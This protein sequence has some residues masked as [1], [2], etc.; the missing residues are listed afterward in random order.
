VGDRPQLRVTVYA[1]NFGPYGFVFKFA[2]ALMALL[3]RRAGVLSD[4]RLRL[5]PP[6]AISL[7]LG[8]VGGT[9]VL[10]PVLLL[11]T[12]NENDG[13]R[14]FL[15]RSQDELVTQGRMEY[16][17]E[18][19]RRYQQC[20]R[21]AARLTT[22]RYGPTFTFL[23]GVANE[24]IEA[25]GQASVGLNPLRRENID[26]TLEDLGANWRGVKDAIAASVGTL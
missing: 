16:P 23:G 21:L 13:F 24:A 11:G 6:P 22:E 17:T 10:S 9:L 18:N 2:A 12:S 15:G 26:E 5:A 4:E 8:S 1:H 14:Y 25:L 7:A 19:I 20:H 3:L